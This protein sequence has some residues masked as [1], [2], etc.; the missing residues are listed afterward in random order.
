MRLEDLD[1]RLTA[2]A[3]S[4]EDLA[5]TEDKKCDANYDEVARLQAKA[6]GLRLARSYVREIEDGIG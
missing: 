2:A 5:A 1:A 6:E 3:R 4:L